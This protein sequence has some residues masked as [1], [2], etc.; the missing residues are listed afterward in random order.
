MKLVVKSRKKIRRIKLMAFSL[1]W[2]WFVFPYNIIREK[3]SR[4]TFLTESYNDTDFYGVEI[5]ERGI[6]D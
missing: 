1:A 6:M 2:S 3:L 5:L 4:F